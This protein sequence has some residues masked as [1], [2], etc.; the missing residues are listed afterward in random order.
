MDLFLGLNSK[1]LFSIGSIG[2]RTGTCKGFRLIV[3]GTVALVHD[4][5]SAQC[6]EYENDPILICVCKRRE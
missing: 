5:I 3:M 4:V 2:D 1:I 6:S